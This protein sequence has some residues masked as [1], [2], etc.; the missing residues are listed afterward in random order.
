MPY[1]FIDTISTALRDALH[2]TTVHEMYQLCLFVIHKKPNLYTNLLAH[3][4]AFLKKIN[5]YFNIRSVI[6]FD[7]MAAGLN[8]RRMIQSAVFKELVKVCGIAH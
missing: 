8:K 7:E 2:T 6:D 5:I 1:L 3:F 4:V